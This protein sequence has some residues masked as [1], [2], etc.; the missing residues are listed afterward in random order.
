MLPHPDQHSEHYTSA[1]KLLPTL[2][3]SETFILNK[4]AENYNIQVDLYNL[5][6]QDGQVIQQQVPAGAHTTPAFKVEQSKVPKFYGQKGKDS[7]LALDF[8]CQI[9]D[10]T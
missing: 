5:G 10:L 1:Y 3:H 7:I 2:P 9:D 6:N 4:M 8:I